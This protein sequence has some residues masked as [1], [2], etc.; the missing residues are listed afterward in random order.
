MTVQEE[1]R[2]A[3]RDELIQEEHRAQQSKGGVPKSHYRRTREMV[4]DRRPNAAVNQWVRAA[5][6]RAC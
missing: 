5:V 3:L 4:G 6:C 1:S 2:E